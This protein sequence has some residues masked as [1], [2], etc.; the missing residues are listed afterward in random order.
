MVTKADKVNTVNELEA[1][2][3]NASAVFTTD[4]LGLSVSQISDLRKKLREHGAKFKIAKNTLIK[5]AAEGSDFVHLTG[6]LSGPTAVLFCFDNLDVEPAS[7]VKSFAKENEEK[8]VFKGAV[9]DG[10]V[11]DADQAKSVA[12]LPSKDVLLSQIAGLLV[13]IPSSVAYIFVEL[14]KKDEDQ[15]KL[16]K[17]FII[18]DEKA[19]EAKAEGET[20]A[21]AEEAK[22]DDNA[23]DANASTEEPKA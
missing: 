8:V 7:A 17:E 22:A 3:K 16:V 19:D 11:L 14:S 21:K 9:L 6:D 13:N 10:D 4:Q 1:D 12:G 5:K 20:E 15:T 18:V 2:F 23:E